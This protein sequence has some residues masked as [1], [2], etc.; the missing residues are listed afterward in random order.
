MWID[1]YGIDSAYDYDPVWAK[2]QELG[3]S[4]SFHWG[5]STSHTNL[6]SCHIPLPVTILI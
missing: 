3:V 6:I 5:C 4:V 1:M 2:C